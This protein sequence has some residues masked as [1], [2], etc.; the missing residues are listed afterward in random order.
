MIERF[1]DPSAGEI[2]FD[3]VRIKDISLTALRGAIG[4]VS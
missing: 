2:S 1:Y 3:D 4:Y